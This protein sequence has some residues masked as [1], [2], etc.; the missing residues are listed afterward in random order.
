[1]DAADGL[2]PET[3]LHILRCVCGAATSLPSQTLRVLATVSTG[4]YGL[5]L[6]AAILPF[7]RHLHCR[8]LTPNHNG[9]RFGEVWPPDE[10]L[11][12]YRTQASQTLGDQD[13]LIRCLQM[14]LHRR[15]QPA[16]DLYSQLEEATNLESWMRQL[17][18]FRA[19][20][21]PPTSG[22]GEAPPPVWC[23]AAVVL[24]DGRLCVVGGGCY[25]YELANAQSSLVEVL[26]H[27]PHVYIFDTASQQWSHQVTTGAQPPVAH[28]YASAHTLLGTRWVFWC[29]GYYCQ[30]YN[31]AFSLDIETWEWRAMRNSSEHQP[32]PRYFAASFEHLGALYAWGGRSLKDKYFNDLWR[33]DRSRAHQDVVHTDEMITSGSCPPARFA[34]T[35]TNCD[36]RFA[37]LFGGGQWKT[38]GRF[39]TDSKVTGSHSQTADT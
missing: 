17:R 34:S 29:G 22:P 1:M 25:S 39:L 9:K 18:D 19:R 8:L 27:Q 24:P 23:A 33:L 21:F 37:I 11:Q 31:T 13:M 7:A 10:P 14:C 15:F 28:A 12:V 35:L 4:W 38:G 26:W 36:D 6:S 30:A 2:P 20:Q 32:S 5:S 3:R 16:M